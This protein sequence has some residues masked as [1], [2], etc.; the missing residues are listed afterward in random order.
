MAPSGPGHT[1]ANVESTVPPFKRVSRSRF[2]Y[3]DHFEVG[4]RTFTPVEICELLEPY[5]S[6]ARQERIGQV[7]AS[8]TYTVV[9]VLER[10]HDAGNMY[11]VMRSAEGL[12]F[13]ALHLVSMEG[14]AAEV[15]RRMADRRSDDSVEGL[16]RS[17]AHRSARTSQGAD[18]WLDPQLWEDA[19]SF[20]RFARERGYRIVATHLDAAAVPI[21]EI[22]F[23]QPTALVMG[24]EKD[25]VSPQMLAHA[26]ATCIL[27]LDGFVQ[28]YN[29]SVAAALGLYHAR[30]DRERRLGA[31]GDLN[32]HER[33]CLRASYYMRSVPA[34]GL[35]LAHLTRSM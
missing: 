30:M 32:E 7:V 20:A 11:A 35:I 26:D 29:V 28:S 13:G 19:D 12:G 34:C 21:S 27:P 9:P 17:A 22:D 4:D 6:E 3:A 2:P 24:N 15:G 5:L 1:L 16:A 23:S 10:V 25:G 18:K 31:H 8:R 14:D 33:L